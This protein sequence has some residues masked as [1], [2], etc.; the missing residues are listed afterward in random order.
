MKHLTE[1]Y[2]ARSVVLDDANS[3]AEL[4]NSY[5]NAL[6]KQGATQTEEKVR[7]QLQSPGFC[8]ERDTKALVSADER[9]VAFCYVVDISGLHTHYQCTGI[10]HPE[11]REQ[12]LGSALVSWI[13]NRVVAQMAMAPSE[14]RIIVQQ[15]ISSKDEEGM[16]LL[17]R[18]GFLEVRKFWQMHIAL[19]ESPSQVACPPSITIRCFDPETDREPLF[20]AMRESLS[21]QWSVNEKAANWSA[22]R[23]RLEHLMA[24]DTGFDPSLWTIALGIDQ[25]VGVSLGSK[26]RTDKGLIGSIHTY[27]VRPAWRR[28]GIGL[29]LLPL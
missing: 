21:E 19:R 20:D 4:M 8:L 10:V 24:T 23:N 12:G 9:I 6:G 16:N 17:S 27:A 3:L 11:F 28:Q 25:V 2:T 26:E 15:G 29:A 7:M 14:A 22:H 5:S 1:K 18:H 13:E